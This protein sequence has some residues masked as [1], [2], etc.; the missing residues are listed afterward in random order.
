[1]FCMESEDRELLFKALQV[2]HRVIY[3]RRSE[4]Q[5][6]LLCPRLNLPGQ[7]HEKPVEFLFLCPYRNLFT[8]P[9]LG[10]NGYLY[11]HIPFGPCLATQEISP[12]PVLLGQLRCTPG[13]VITFFYLYKTLSACTLTPTRGVYV[14][15][16]HD[17]WLEKRCRRINLY[18]PIVWKKSYIESAHK[19][20][21]CLSI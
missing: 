1:M 20:R 19:N 8:W 6:Y 15:P 11:D 13:I 10:L 18:G 5:T 3:A 17:G 12:I 4:L 7:F 2:G 9:Y 21:S 16:C 14:R